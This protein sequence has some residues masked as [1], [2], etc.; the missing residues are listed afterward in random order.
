MKRTALLSMA[1]ALAI[2]LPA[3]ATAQTK[4]KPLW[5]RNEPLPHGFNPG[6]VFPTI[7][8]PSAVDGKPISIA[9][10]RGRKVIVNIFASW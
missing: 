7:A 9:D 10:F 6:D 1:A 5:A 3:D 8:L 2:A 4:P